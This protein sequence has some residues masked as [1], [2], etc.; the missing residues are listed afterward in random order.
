MNLTNFRPKTNIYY[1]LKIFYINPE[2][3]NLIKYILFSWLLKFNKLNNTLIKNIKITNL[4]TLQNNT[5][6]P[7]IKYNKLDKNLYT[8]SIRCNI[9][10]NKVFYK[11]LFNVYI[12][13]FIYS[14]TEVYKV[15][16]SFRSLYIYNSSKGLNIINIKKIN[17]HWLIICTFLYN[18][19]LYNLH[20]ILFSN[21]FLKNEILSL[22]WLS[23]KN[24]N[25]KWRYNKLFQ[26]LTPLPYNNLSN[27]FIKLI[28]NIGFRL[29]LITDIN[30]H[31]STITYLHKYNIYIFGLVPTIYNI[32][33]VDISLPISSDNLYMQVFFIKFLLKL[34][35]NVEYNKY[36]HYLTTWNNN[37]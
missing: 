32:K 3:T 1:N 25:L 30:Y 35:K 34:R 4:L 21:V 24:F 13:L 29:T 33:Q 10:S 5:S 19:H 9:I 6:T 12:N 8:K 22:N 27:I 36:N 7:Q 11:K 16:H 26:F 23:L 14:F 18:I 28:Y 2:I 31:N 17:N 15:H 37:L 20:P